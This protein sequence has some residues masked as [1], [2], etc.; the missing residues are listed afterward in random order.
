MQKDTKKKYRLKIT[1]E[2][3]LVERKKK[4]YKKDRKIFSLFNPY[5]LLYNK[6][7][8]YKMNIF[9]NTDIFEIRNLHE[10]SKFIFESDD[11]KQILNIANKIR[12]LENRSILVFNILFAIFSLITII[13]SYYFKS[14]LIMLAL[15]PVSIIFC[16]IL[17]PRV[18]FKK[19]YE[20]IMVDIC[21]FAT[22]LVNKRN[23]FEYSSNSKDIKKMKRGKWLIDKKLISNTFK[24]K[25]SDFNSLI[26]KI[27]IRDTVDHFSI[28][29]G[30]IKVSKKKATIFSGYAFEFSS[31][32]IENLNNDLA[33]A[34]VNK[35][36][37]I[38][39]NDSISED[40]FSG[41]KKLELNNQILSRDWS[42]Y[43][44]KDLAIDKKLI[45]YI[46]KQVLAIENNIDT[47][48]LY[49]FNNCIRLLLSIKSNR[50]GLMTNYFDTSLA[51]SKQLSFT[52]FY[53]NIK[54]LY[55]YSC[56]EKIALYIRKYKP[57][58]ADSWKLNMGR[59]DER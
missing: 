40:D 55:L 17:Y 47:F 11:F 6:A 41:M 58:K 44:K 54:A 53:S 46:Q 25:T 37:L 30:K 23:G 16:I 31:N 8:L 4:P 42:I 36:T 28:N 39:N 9:K 38:N 15:I 43:V 24:I 32:A 50:D 14:P 33:I 49:F 34:F 52:G 10:R 56:I 59:G 12:S 5:R 19:F 1:L 21:V 51:N 2:K 26:E 7:I 57:L 3:T 35:K 20:N 45:S 48:N 29:N 22:G 27:V 13:V 18:S